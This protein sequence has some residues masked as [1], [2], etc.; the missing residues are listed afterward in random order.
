MIVNFISYS[1]T[2]I[3]GIQF[4]GDLRKNHLVSLMFDFH[5]L[6]KLVNLFTA[7]MLIRK[8]KYL[9]CKE[10]RLREYV[11]LHLTNIDKTRSNWP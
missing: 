10:S 6:L 8:T 2:D 4:I 7:S 5:S 9:L 11:L 1:F 3:L